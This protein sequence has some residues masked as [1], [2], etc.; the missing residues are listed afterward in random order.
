MTLTQTHQPDEMADVDGALDTGGQRT[1]R[2]DRDVDAPRLAEQPLV[3]DIVD[4]SDHPP[5]PELGLGEQ[6]DDQVGFVVAGRGDH[7][8][9]GLRP[10]LLQRGQLAGV[11]EQPVG[12]GNGVRF[13]TPP[14]A[15]DEQHL[16]AVFE[17][18]ARDGAADVTGARYP[19]PHL[20]YCHPA[21]LT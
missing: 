16:V 4:A 20:A 3:V 6:T 8:I 2:R 17:Q 1:R 9:A 11:G 13:E 19:D 15:F 7:H 5:Y 12:A 14:L 21:I 18:F 10:R